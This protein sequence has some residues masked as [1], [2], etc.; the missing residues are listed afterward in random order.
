[1]IILSPNPSYLNLLKDGVRT[2]DVLGGEGDLDVLGGGG[3]LDFLGGGGGHSLA[4]N[5]IKGQ[6]TNQK[7]STALFIICKHRFYSKS[8]LKLIN[9]ADE[10]WIF[11]FWHQKVKINI[12]IFPRQKAELKMYRR[13]L[14][15]GT[16]CSMQMFINALKGANIKG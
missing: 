15:Y 10:S 1:M 14:N 11:C 16:F 9:Y 13:V 12:I 8:F 2:L 6:P 4:L 7:S 3:D 5:I